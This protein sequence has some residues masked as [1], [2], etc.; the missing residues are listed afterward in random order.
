M[1]VALAR[2]GE[3]PIMPLTMI[4]S[5]WGVFIKFLLVNIFLVSFILPICFREPSHHWFLQA[6]SASMQIPCQYRKINKY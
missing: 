1:T 6:V 3:M 2:P 4:A 5:I